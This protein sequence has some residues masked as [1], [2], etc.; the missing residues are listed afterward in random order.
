MG[1]FYRRSFAEREEFFLSYGDHEL[2]FHRGYPV[3]YVMLHVSNDRSLPVCQGELNYISSSIL[4]DG[5]ILHAKIRSDTALVIWMTIT[6]NE[7]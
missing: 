2:I 3:K 1:S 7:A 5:F 6:D 4:D